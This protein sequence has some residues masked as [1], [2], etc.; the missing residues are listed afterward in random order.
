MFYLSFIEYCNLDPNLIFFGD[1]SNENRIKSYNTLS[2]RPTSVINNESP[3]RL[4]D[5]NWRPSLYHVMCC[6]PIDIPLL[7]TEQRNSADA[8]MWTLII[9]GIISTCNGA[10]MVNRNS[11][12]ASPPVFETRHLYEPASS[13]VTASIA[14]TG[15]ST[16]I[17]GPLITDSDS[18]LLLENHLERK[19]KWKWNNINLNNSIYTRTKTKETCWK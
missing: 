11:A 13:L 12:L 16:R 18:M 7:V 10:V 8:P 3:E 5:G 19:W 14:N 4:E 2:S 1:I 15:P 17:R 6:N 9:F